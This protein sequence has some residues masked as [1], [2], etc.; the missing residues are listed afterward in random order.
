MS[1]SLDTLENRRSALLDQIGQLGDFRPGSIT[2]TSGRCGNPNCHC[3]LP[4]EPAHGPHFRLTFRRQGKTVTESFPTAAARRNTQRQIAQYRKWQ[5]LSRVLVAVNTRICQLRPALVHE[6]ASARTL[7]SARAPDPSWRSRGNGMAAGKSSRVNRKYKTKYRIWNWSEYER[8]L[9]SR[10]DVTIW[11]SE[12]A[13]AAWTPPKNGLRG[14]QRRYSNLVI[15]T[16]LTLRVVFRLPLRQSEG[17]LDSLLSLMGLDLKAPDHTTLS[18]RSRIVA[19]PPL[20]RAH[21]G[22]I[23]LIVDSTGLKILGSGEWNAHKYKA[24]KRR[25]NWRKLHIGVDDEE[26]IVA[27]KLTTSSGDDTSALPDLLDQ[28]EVPIRRFTADGAYD[29]R[30]IYDRVGAAGTEDVVIVIPPRRCAVSAGPT[31]DPWA[32]REAALQRIREIGR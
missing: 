18:R 23:H 27:A 25:R 10:G 29:H 16:A 14:G 31:D 11:L 2:T 19:V 21:G 12:E 30:S 13:I 15:L 24:S 20:T 22:P 3:H 28:I 7:A 5:Q 26:F 1:A 9:R 4:G 32:Q 8:G 6:S 17:F